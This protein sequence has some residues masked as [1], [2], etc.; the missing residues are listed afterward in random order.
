MPSQS[1]VSGVFRDIS[2]DHIMIKLCT[3]INTI[4]MN[5]LLGQWCGNAPPAAVALV[6]FRSK[7]TL[8]SVDI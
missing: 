2:M 6:L 1:A 4:G 7:K 5:N 8:L 3:V